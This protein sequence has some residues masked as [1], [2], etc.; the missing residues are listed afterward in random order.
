MIIRRGQIE[1]REAQALRDRLDLE[2]NQPLLVAKL[3]ALLKME[4]LKGSDAVKLRKMLG[5]KI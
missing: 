2:G 1:Y 4:Y 5:Y 3:D